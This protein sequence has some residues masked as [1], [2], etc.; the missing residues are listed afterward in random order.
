MSGPVKAAI[1]AMFNLYQE[2]VAYL[3]QIKTEPTFLL[4]GK[5]YVETQISFSES[6][7]KQLF[8]PW[9]FGNL[10]ARHIR[11]HMR[12]DPEQKL[13][14]CSD[15]GFATEAQPVVDIFGKKNTLLVKIYREGKTFAGDSRS[16]IDI[17]GVQ[18]VKLFNNGTV[19][20]YHEAIEDLL[21]GWVNE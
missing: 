9:I 18:T 6:W 12:D 3:E 13:Y 19:E 14:V 8:D 17:E 7:A 21:A 20:E 16:Y 5:S 4:F 15:S 10:A 1:R 11:D 2:E